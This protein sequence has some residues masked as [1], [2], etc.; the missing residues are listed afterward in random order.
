[1]TRSK[2]RDIKITHDGRFHA[3]G[4]VV[5]TFDEAFDRCI[6]KTKAAPDA[7]CTLV[8]FEDEPFIDPRDKEKTRHWNVS[9]YL[10]GSREYLRQALS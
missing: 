7:W 1:M 8:L 10:P 3:M 9:F 2:N 6:E 4:S 5:S